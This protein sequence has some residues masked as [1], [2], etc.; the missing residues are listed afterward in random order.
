MSSHR[1]SSKSP[2]QGMEKTLRDVFGEMNSMTDWLLGMDQRMSS[3]GPHTFHMGA[4]IWVDR[5]ANVPHTAPS[6][7]DQVH[8][9]V[10][11]VFRSGQCAW[12]H[13][14]FDVQG[15]LSFYTTVMDKY[16]SVKASTPAVAEQT[17]ASI[18]LACRFI[19][20]S[21]RSPDLPRFYVP[22]AHFGLAFAKDFPGV[23]VDACPDDRTRRLSSGSSGASSSV[24]PPWDMIS[25]SAQCDLL[26]TPSTRVMRAAP[27]SPPAS[28]R[29]PHK[30]EYP[31]G[32]KCM[33]MHGPCLT[34]GIVFFFLAPFLVVRILQPLLQWLPMTPRL[35]LRLQCL[36]PW[37][38]PCRSIRFNL[39][40]QRKRGN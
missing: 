20:F 32:C 14:S 33:L 26:N 16:L 39:R 37:T 38:P 24:I 4:S 8:A 35:H 19:A 40:P 22:S 18:T 5:R 25:T 27:A 21:F 23:W 36:P 31:T 1:K 29:T 12:P 11:G 6:D 34:M 17:H 3:M 13:D 15:G 7:V 28:G 30:R 9:W 2:M 10:L